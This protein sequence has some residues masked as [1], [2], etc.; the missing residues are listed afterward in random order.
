MAISGH[1]LEAVFK[2]YNI[3]PGRDIKD[4]GHQAGILSRKTEKAAKARCTAPAP[5]WGQ[6]GDNWPTCAA[7]EKNEPALTS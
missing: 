4:A 7:V 5:E 3:A 6:F 1:R 2:R